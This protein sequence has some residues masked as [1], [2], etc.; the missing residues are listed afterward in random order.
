MSPLQV[1]VKLFG[2]TEVA[3]TN[4]FLLSL[5]DRATLADA[6]RAVGQ[7]GGE[8]LQAALWR[9][10]NHLQDGIRVVVG[11]E[12]VDRLERNLDNGDQLF[13]LHELAGGQLC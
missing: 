6:L 10:D 5:P 8:K 1:Q 2:L 9:R 13:I 4:Q 7:Q 3:S 12:V 11:N